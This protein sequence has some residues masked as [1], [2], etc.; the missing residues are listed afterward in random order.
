[1]PPMPGPPPRAESSAYGSIAVR[2]QPGDAEVLIDGEEWRASGGQ[3]R[4]VVEVP[5]GPHRIEIRK[6][7]YRGYMADVQVRRGETTRINV[8]LRSQEEQ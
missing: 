8:S 3:D 1:M 5:E 6:P 4:L 2:V 7:G